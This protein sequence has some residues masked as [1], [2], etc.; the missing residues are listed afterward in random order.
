MSTLLWRYYYEDDFFNFQRVIETAAV[1][2]IGAGR[3]GKQRNTSGQPVSSTT[4]SVGSPRDPLAMSPETPRGF[5]NTKSTGNRSTFDDLTLTRADINRKDSKGM[6]LLHHAASR[7]SEGGI[8]FALALIAHPLIDLYVQDLESG[9]TALHRAFY[10][11]NITIARAILEREAQDAIGQGGSGVVTQNIT[12]M[13][14]KDRE[15]NGPYDLLTSIIKDRT[16]HHTLERGQNVRDDDVD[17]GEEPESDDDDEDRPQRKAVVSPLINVQGDEL[18]TFGSN[19]NVNLGL[20]NHDDRQHPER[21]I[22]KRPAHLYKR[23]YR[24]LI[25]KRAADVAT[26]NPTYAE[27]ILSVLRQGMPEAEDLPAVIQ[28]TPESIQ[29]VQMSKYH[30]AVLTNDPL[31]NLYMT[32]HGVGGRLGTGSEKTQFSFVCIEDFGGQRKKIVAIALGQDHSLAITDQGEIFSWGSNALGQLGLGAPKSSKPEECVEVTPKQIFGPL[33]REI[34]YG[35]AASR[36]HSVAHTSDGLY[37]FGKNEGQLGIMDAHARSLEL[38]AIPRRVAASRFSCPIRSVSA[39]DRATICLLENDEVHVFANYGVVK[40]QFPLDF[41][42]SFLKQSFLT[43]RYDTTPNKVIKITGGGDT[44][45]ALSSAGEIFSVVVGQSND[46]GSSTTNPNKIK[47]ALST[48]ARIWS[49]KKGHMNAKDVGVDQDGAI[50]LSTEAGSVWRRTVRAAKRSQKE[51]KFSRVPGLTRAIAVRA[52]SSGAYCAIRQD[53]DVTKQQIIPNKKT[54]WKDMSALLPFKNFIAREDA[55]SEIQ[56]LKFWN[57]PD[58]FQKLMTSLVNS[59]DLEKDLD[60]ALKSSPNDQ[61]FNYDLLVCTS[62]SEVRIPAHQFVFSGRSSLMRQAFREYHDQGTYAC[63][64]FT[65]SDGPE[66]RVLLTTSF[67]FLTHVELILYLYT[68]RFVGFWN[69]AR[70]VNTFRYREVVGKEIRKIASRLELQNLEAAARRVTDKAAKSMDRDLELAMLDSDFLQ[71][72]DTIIELADGAEV[73]VHAD[74]IS[75]RVP[76]FDGLFHGRAGGRWLA[77]RRDLLADPEDAV[78]IDMQ[79]VPA[80]VFSLVLRHI[81]TDAGEELFDDVVT[82]DLNEF[83][84]L[85]LEVLSV[86]NELMMDRLSQVCQMVIGRYVNV[87]N[88][89]DLLNA[90]GPSAVEDFKDAGLEY[91]CLNLEAMLSSHL[92]DELDE[93][94][95]HDLDNV[96]RSNQLSVL[97]YAKSGRAEA[98]LLENHP[99]LPARLDRDRQQKLDSINL[100]SK[101][102][103]GAT[104]LGTSFDLG[105]EAVIGSSRSR[106]ARASASGSTPTTPAMQAQTPTAELGSSVNDNFLSPDV[107]RKPALAGSMPRSSPLDSSPAAYPSRPTVGPKSPSDLFANSLKPPGQKQSLSASPGVATPPAMEFLKVRA[108]DKPWGATPLASAKLDLREILEQN[109]SAGPSGIALGLAAQK[110]PSAPAPPASMPK[111]SQ[112]ERRKAS[113]QTSDLL[114]SPAET[115]SVSNSP[116]QTAGTRTKPVPSPSLIPSPA[117]PSP[118]AVGQPPRPSTT[119]QL[120]MRQTLAN[121]PQR[122]G[123]NVTSPTSGSSKSQAKL[124]HRTASTSKDSIAAPSPSD[125]AM[126][127]GFS[128]SQTAAPIPVQSVRH[129]PRPEAEISPT[130]YM[131]QSMAD[132]LAQQ[133]AEKTNIKEA[134]AKRSLQEIQQEEEFLTWWAKESQ[135]VKEEEERALRAAEKAS[136]RGGRGGGRGRGGGAGGRGGDTSI[137]GGKVNGGGKSARKPRGE[138]ATPAAAAPAIP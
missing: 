114:S 128:I 25:N 100:L 101:F 17:H 33:K 72:A 122:P 94:L 79:H 45:C 89:C 2:G 115:P 64:I 27:N 87:R 126:G 37:T 123:P 93:D 130:F 5:K 70:G 107:L 133:R 77:E 21:V 90:I 13:K 20:G 51:F 53:C 127:P 110:Q 129:V 106:K 99:E 28:F 103:E 68:D 82:K 112:K 19:K 24:E 4:F 35:V 83:L 18:Y 52:S 113:R 56:D 31:S 32:G 74:L 132:I 111:M 92:L 1:A 23:F 86:A 97:P 80:N 73:R 104:T 81:Y 50:I 88:A 14:I 49:L 26:T 117:P 63:D 34:I 69:R 75:R 119:P 131:H 55:D 62:M 54:L 102:A 30:T 105:I 9:W 41:T 7:V 39:I 78:S 58:I 65:L 6:T 67:D 60:E 47:A 22:L 138:T 40:V 76:F 36:I 66:D 109:S 121:T 57:R 61:C 91:L 95:L 134:A 96:V 38:Q 124:A 108:S 44:I 135:A 29:D 136:K 71:Y 16:L 10:F 8:N 48:P 84:D 12:L 43:T 85:I 120:T 118:A 46:S 137:R 3:G 59:K 98:L 125:R 42:G 116:W 15:G 11:G